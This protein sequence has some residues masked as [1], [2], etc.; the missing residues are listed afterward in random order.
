MSEPG[1][2]T[3]VPTH[4]IG[5][6]P[7]L[8][9]QTASI[10]SPSP[11]GDARRVAVRQLRLTPQWTAPRSPFR[12]T[13]EGIINVDQFRWMVRRDMQEQLELAQR[14]LRATHVR[15]VG[16]YDDEMRA[17]CQSPAA[18]M[19][20]EPK[21]PRTN[22][23]TIDY[24][25]D[26]LLDRKLQP[27]F[28]TSFIPS[29][30]ASGPL[31]VFST[32]AHTS[33]PRD[34]KEWEN[35]V[36]DSVLHAVDRYSLAVV[37]QW[38]FEVWNEPNLKNWFWGGDLADFY[39][40][41]ATTYRAIKSVDASLRVG[42]PS[43]GRA[44]WVQ[45][46]LEYGAAH[47]CSPD[48]LITHI[49]NND[50]AVDDP[51]APFDPSSAARGSTSPTFAQDMMRRVR[52]LLDRQQFKGELHWN[53]WGRSFHA[54]DFR[55]EHPSEAAFIARLLADASQ[56]ADAFAYW[57]LSDIYD[58][59]GY[60]REAFFGGYGLLNLQGLRKPAYH[61]FELLSRLGHERV[62]T[63]GHGTDAMCN[64]I[65]TTAPDRV[66]HVLVYASDDADAPERKSIA[67]T[68]DL[69][70]G[71]RP[72]RLYRIDSLENNVVARWRE[73]GA[74]AYLSRAQA[75]ELAADNA[76]RASSTP[77]HFENTGAASH[78]HFTM[79]GPG[80]A[81]LELEMPASRSG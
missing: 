42:G 12:H 39:R 5:I 51:L 37:R 70:T 7:I 53:E 47:D 25:I 58:Q 79:E 43:T 75:K 23:Q 30:L 6:M 8:A 33:P 14:E 65:V 13:W 31:T 78:A 69:P 57:C 81:L 36:R 44:E 18:F 20:H 24:V 32:R 67:V 4:R 29:A 66:A 16:I 48:Y 60:G 19:G 2:P 74:P 46:L 10:L 71:S 34:W 64:A 3:H 45:E 1:V 61:A 55:R 52:A 72:T 35:F 62:V 38:P 9:G 49:Y 11:D 77:V 17:F 73:L 68:V 41:W 63:N 26:S 15:A 59:V 21:Q 76:L 54:V 28:T 22:W 50:S 40:L 56:E 80:V 27:V